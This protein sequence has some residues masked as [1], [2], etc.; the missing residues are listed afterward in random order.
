MVGVK[1]WILFLVKRSI[2]II[3]L[4]ELFY[5]RFREIIVSLGLEILSFY[6]YGLGL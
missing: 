2:L 5:F 3:Y 6:S 1:F 4:L